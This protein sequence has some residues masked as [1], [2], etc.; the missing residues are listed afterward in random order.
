[1]P[2]VG[3]PGELTAHVHCRTRGRSVQFDP[4]RI[5]PAP[6]TEPDRRRFWNLY[7]AI[8]GAIRPHIRP[9]A[10]TGAAHFRTKHFPR[11]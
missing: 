6:L 2:L 4:R 8:S 10:V 1:M 5:P 7:M 3:S 11:S 9:D